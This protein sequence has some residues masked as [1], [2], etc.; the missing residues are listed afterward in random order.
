MCG[1]LSHINVKR[2]CF[3][4]VIFQQLAIYKLL[5]YQQLETAN[6]KM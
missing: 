2:K 5:N 1:Y 4:Y 6:F 3:I